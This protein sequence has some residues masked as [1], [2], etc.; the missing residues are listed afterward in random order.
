M[1]VVCMVCVRNVSTRLGCSLSSASASG[2]WVLWLWLHICKAATF[3]FSASC[4]KKSGFF[5]LFFSLVA[6]YALE[7][8]PGLDPLCWLPFLPTQHHWNSSVGAVLTLRTS[9]SE[10]FLFLCLSED[11]IAR[12]VLSVSHLEA[13]H[14]V[15]I[16]AGRACAKFRTHLMSGKICGINVLLGRMQQTLREKVNT[17]S[18]L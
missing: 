5:W 14:T 4:K 15:C 6:I 11:T 17:Q 10:L 13:S 7:K 16:K 3:K 9:W 8:H 18:V 12:L 2:L 1:K